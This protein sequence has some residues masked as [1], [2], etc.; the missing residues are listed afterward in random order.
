MGLFFFIPFQHSIIIFFTK[1][2]IIITSISSLIFFFGLQSLMRSLAFLNVVIIRHF[3]WNIRKKQKNSHALHIVPQSKYSNTR[4]TK[5]FRQCL[6][7]VR[8][9]KKHICHSLIHFLAKILLPQ[10]VK[11]TCLFHF[12][13]S[14]LSILPPLDKT[15]PFIPYFFQ[16]LAYPFQ[17]LLLIV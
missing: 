12:M 1:F 11:C 6:K 4:M 14:Q 15:T 17:C 2:S 13:S 3:C 9:H 8:T 7:C 16:V 10:K 5:I